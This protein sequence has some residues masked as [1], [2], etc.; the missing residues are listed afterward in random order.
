MFH[1]KKVIL[2]MIVGF[3]FLCLISLI[4]PKETTPPNDAR[5]ILEHTSETY[6]APSCFEQADATN[7][8][9]EGK[10][11]EAEELSYQAHDDCTK[12]AFQSEKDSLFMSTLKSIGLIKTKW[13]E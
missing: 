1:I 3:V 7:F 9:Q 5:V 13:D 11:E 4:I 6:I 12:K 10:L 2:F 8:L